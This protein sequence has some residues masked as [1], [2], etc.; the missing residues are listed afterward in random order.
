MSAIQKE[1]KQKKKQKKRT[2]EVQGA[3]DKRKEKE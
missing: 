1:G 3:N 2:E